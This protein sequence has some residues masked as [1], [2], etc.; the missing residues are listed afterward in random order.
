M[1]VYPLLHKK[2][3]KNLVAFFKV[4]VNTKVEHVLGRHRLASHRH[5]K[6]KY[7]AFLQVEVFHLENYDNHHISN[8]PNHTAFRDSLLALLASIL[9]RNEHK[10]YYYYTNGID[11]T[12][13][14]THPLSC[15]R[16][17]KPDL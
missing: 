12:P 11:L 14:L 1:A 9:H 13:T 4:G 2:A 10:G 17:G 5:L 3:T 16:F 7:Q 6:D 8:F 15:Q